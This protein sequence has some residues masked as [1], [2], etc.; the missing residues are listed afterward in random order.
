MCLSLACIIST[1]QFKPFTLELR[2][3]GFIRVFLSVGARALVYLRLGQAQRGG[4]LHSLWRG[5]VPLDLES[6][7]QAG[8][9]RVGEDR[10]GLPAPAVL[11]R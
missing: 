7:L 10:P 4:Q 6:L 11:P 1:I 5:Q 2:V 8:Q 9:L 3:F